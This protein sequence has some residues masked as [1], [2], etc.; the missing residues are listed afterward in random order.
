MHVGTIGFYTEEGCNFE[1][2]HFVCIAC[3]DKKPW[4]HSAAWSPPTNS[5]H[6]WRRW[7]LGR[8]NQWLC[9]EYIHCVVGSTPHYFTLHV[10]LKQKKTYNYYTALIDLTLLSTIDLLHI[11]NFLNENYFLRNISSMRNKKSLLT[12]SLGLCQKW[13]LIFSTPSSARKLW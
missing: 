9:F 3:C 5:Q 4:Y 6:L 10:S 7:F 2:N 13:K 1:W 12:C 8:L 11:G